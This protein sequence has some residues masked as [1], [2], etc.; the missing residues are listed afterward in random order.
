MT[1]Y[2]HNPKVISSEVYVQ[3]ITSYLELVLPDRAVSFVLC[4]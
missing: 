2:A 3:L 4:D 1:L